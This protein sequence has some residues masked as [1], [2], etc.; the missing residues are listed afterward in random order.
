MRELRV[1]HQNYAWGARGNSAVRALA[2]ANALRFDDALDDD[3]STPFAEL[4]AGTHSS[5]MST[6]KRD[7]DEGG[8]A[9]ETLRSYVDANAMRALGETCVKR[10]GTTRDVPFLMKMLSVSTALRRPSTAATHCTAARL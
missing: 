9:M 10:F 8:D 2:S 7:D 4:W 1:R 6:T 3:D 5:G